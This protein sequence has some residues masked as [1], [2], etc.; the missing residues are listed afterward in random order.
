[1][2]T[3]PFD[4]LENVLL[5]YVDV[6]TLLQLLCVNNTLRNLLQASEQSWL[7]EALLHKWG[8]WIFPCAWDGCTCPDQHS[9]ITGL[10][11]IRRIAKQQEFQLLNLSSEFPVVPAHASCC[12]AQYF[13]NTCILVG[14]LPITTPEK[15]SKLRRLLDA[16][17]SKILKV[18]FPDSKQ[19]VGF[20]FILPWDTE[21]H[22]NYTDGLIVFE[23]HHR[24][25]QEDT[26]SQVIRKLHGLRLDKKHTLTAQEVEMQ[27]LLCEHGHPK[28]PM[29]YWNPVESRP[30]PVTFSTNFSLVEQGRGCVKQLPPQLPEADQSGLTV[31][32]ARVNIVGNVVQ[33]QAP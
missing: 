24:T 13:L 19:Q 29:V 33:K 3:I 9:P 8:Y 23:D 31:V 26:C 21:E 4:V 20:E 12:R 16:I 30:E 6:R 1:M 15:Q 2:N 11:V 14:G 25:T 5:P 17:I 32:P 22:Q 18:R 10:E 28:L 27:L 7:W